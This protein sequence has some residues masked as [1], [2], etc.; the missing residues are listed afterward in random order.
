[1][2]VFGIYI[3][4]C[5]SKSRFNYNCLMCIVKV[6]QQ[7]FNEHIVSLHAFLATSAMV[8]MFFVMQ[9]LPHTLQSHLPLHQSNHVVMKFSHASSAKCTFLTSTMSCSTRA[10][11]QHLQRA[12]YIYIYIYR[13][14]RGKSQIEE[15]M[16]WG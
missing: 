3:Y 10:H 7:Q 2:Y 5:V 4:I 8:V 16:T 13:G 15:H 9:P 14:G 6:G 12:T 1:M 11:V